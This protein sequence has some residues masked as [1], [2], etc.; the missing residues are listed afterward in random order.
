MVLGNPTQ[1]S[2]RPRRCLAIR[3]KLKAWQFKQGIPPLSGGFQ[4]RGTSNRVTVEGA[5]NEELYSGKNPFEG[6][7]VVPEPSEKLLNQRQRVDYRTD[8]EQ[9][10]EWLL[11]FG[12]DPNSAEGYAYS[13]VKNRASRM[14]QFYRWSGSKRTGIH[15]QSRLAMRMRI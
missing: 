6:I 5:G 13:T 1:K 9:C 7:S 10:L 4:N 12:K 15:P 3:Q 11:T 8:R 2:Y 14:D